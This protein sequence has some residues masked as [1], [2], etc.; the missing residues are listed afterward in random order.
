MRDSGQAGDGAELCEAK[1][2]N[3]CGPT[4]LTVR[5]VANSNELLAAMGS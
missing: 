1:S 2:P 4:S 3:P 5:R